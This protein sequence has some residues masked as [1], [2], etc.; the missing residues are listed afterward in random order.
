MRKKRTYLDQI[1]VFRDERPDGW[2]SGLKLRRRFRWWRER[3]KYGFDERE[4][5]ALDKTIFMFL[6]ERLKRYDEVN[7]IN[8]S[9]H[10]KEYNGIV[11]TFQEAINRMI[12]L[13]ED[14]IIKVDSLEIDDGCEGVSRIEQKAEELFGLLSVWIFHLWW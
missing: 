12:E 3:R 9:F 5:W 1:G 14:L 4:T 8:T 11:M 2:T 10:K 6:Y 7:T 13:S